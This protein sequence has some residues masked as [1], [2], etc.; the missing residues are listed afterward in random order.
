MFRTFKG[1][2]RV[3]ALVAT[4]LC[5][6]S[7][8]NAGLLSRL[9][10]E[11]GDAAGSAGKHIDT[12]KHLLD[13]GASLAKR[14]PRV[15][16]AASLAL[17]PAPGKAWQLVTPDGKSLQLASLHDLPNALDDAARQAHRPLA[18]DVPGKPKAPEALH[19]ALRE[20]DFFKL[21]DKLDNLPPNARPMMVRPDGKSFELKPVRVPGG[22]RLAVALSPDVL[23]NPATARALDANIRF[24]SRPVK[25]ADLKMARF[26]SAEVSAVS[27]P[28]DL[29]ANL[30]ADILASSLAK[31]KNRTLV[32]SGRIAPHPQTGRP[33][34]G[35]RDGKSVREIDLDAF[36]AAAESQR[37][38]LMLVESNSLVQP[39]QSWFSKT[40]LEKRFEAAQSAMTQAD[41]LKALSP[42][43]STTL[44]HA[45]DERN[46][47]L[48]TATR[49]SPVANPVTTSPEVSV[50]AGDDYTLAGWLLDASLRTSVRTIH[51]NGED[52][53]HTEEVE[54]RWIPW[55]SNFDLIL[56][57]VLT[58]VTLFMSWYLWRW[59]NRFW[60]FVL[61][62]RA[63]TDA[64]SLP[65]KL[66]KVVF[67]LP[68]ALI[69]LVP[70]MIWLFIGDWVRF[71]TWPFRK[72][73]GR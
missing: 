34:L 52:P 17:V 42:P 53:E 62:N 57:S 39:G 5:L 41:L 29:L 40:A 19:L 46:F 44:I 58:V 10:R 24:L 28:G 11:A 12:P 32:V 49:F 4:T 66:V 35:V 14:L 59:W 3:L 23:I 9:A 64:T 37:V 31:Y 43:N 25:R 1:S 47:R 63:A 30:N 15:T 38:N 36:Q 60:R 22:T 48:V 72:A 26:S 67:F 33:Q 8:A 73:F 45:A 61:G 65:L 21:R 54:S 51:R 18:G 56:L 50:S 71:L 69:M 55:I 68:F 16:G 2:F 6:V 13:E 70:A 20:T 27:G 7:T